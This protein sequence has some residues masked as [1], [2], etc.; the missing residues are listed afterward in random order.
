MQRNRTGNNSGDEEDEDDGHVEEEKK[1]RLVWEY[2]NPKIYKEY[3]L[4]RPNMRKSKAIATAIREET[5]YIVPPYVLFARYQV[6]GL[7]I[8]NLQKLYCE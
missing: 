1:R 4:L 3:H 5:G 2:C 6:A 8:R 7:A